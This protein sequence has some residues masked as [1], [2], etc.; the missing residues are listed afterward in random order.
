MTRLLSVEETRNRLAEL[1][2]E[3]SGGWRIDGTRLSR[4]YRFAG[5]AEAFGFMAEVA[6]HAERAD[7]HPE[8]QNVYN[9]VDVQ[10]TTHDAGGLTDRDFAL[11]TVMERVNR[12]RSS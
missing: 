10:L 9:R 2:T 12:Q 7:H 3:G 4:S 5:F 1:N 8:W 11:A 6:L